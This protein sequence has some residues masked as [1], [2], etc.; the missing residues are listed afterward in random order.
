MFSGWGL[1]SPLR[2]ISS[3]FLILLTSVGLPFFAVSTTAPLLQRWFGSTRHRLA[4][5]PFFLY[6]AS[7][8]GSIGALLLYPI[9]V[10]P[11][12][13]L[14]TQRLMWSD[15]YGVL[16]ILTLACIFLVRRSLA[17]AT[18]QR[19]KIEVSPAVPWLTRLRWI[20]LSAVPS[21]LLLGVTT[22]ITVDIAPVPLLWVIPLTI[23]LVAFV[24]AFSRRTEFLTRLAAIALPFVVLIPLGVVLGQVT[25]PPGFMIFHLVVFFIA[26]MVCIGE[27]AASRPAVS[28][29]TE[30]YV[31]LAVG[32]AI[33]GVFNV[34]VAPF[35]FKTEAE[36][37][38]ALLLAC[39]LRRNAPP[40]NSK[41]FA[42]AIG[43]GF[44]TLMAEFIVGLFLAGR[45]S[46]QFVV[47]SLLIPALI[48]VF[49][50]RNPMRFALIAAAMSIALVVYPD[51]SQSLIATDRSFYGVH[52]ILNRGS[53]R[54]LMHGNTHHGAQ[55]L[56]RE[57]RCVPLSYYYPTGPLGELFAT[58]RIQRKTDIAV[59]GLGTGSTGGYSQ[60]E[61][62]WTFYEIDPAIERIARDPRYFTFLRDCVPQARVVIGDARISLASEPDSTHDVLIVDAFSSDAIPLHLLT[63]EA[64]GLYKRKLKPRGV[65][66]F[67]I[68]NRFVNLRRVL[69]TLA[70]DENLVAYVREDRGVTDLEA[71]DGKLPSVWVAMARSNR[72]L[73]VSQDRQWAMFPRDVT[74][75]AWTDDYTNVLETLKVHF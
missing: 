58:F 69:A 56:R 39:A 5:D 62:R 54:V 10:E 13:H 59:V 28:H 23:Y 37:P 43:I 65:L 66:V 51:R 47:Y 73:I 15:G 55:S 25:E 22:H 34:L 26:A 46:L 9:I 44:L 57:R 31:W 50:F 24:L 11:R 6:A 27:L 53:Y 35:V 48:A 1:T 49:F 70:R 30:F 33:G 67:H 52:R 19:E 75:A 74:G 60:P 16:V 38:L 8:L 20:A 71:Y 64:I 7:N 61:E 4:S 45:G 36:Y 63:R 12:F 29:L 68:S 32:G 2:P 3:V 18:P 40:P 21:S 41:D 42:I 17:D 72:D 14:R